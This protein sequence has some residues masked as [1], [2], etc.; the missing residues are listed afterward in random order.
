MEMKTMYNL[1]TVFNFEVK[2]TLKKKS[3]WI[4]S[5]IFPVIIAA[6]FGIIY[7]SNKATSDAANNAQNQHFSIA[8]TDESGLI[9][10]NIL[11]AVK[12]KKIANKQTGITAVKTGKVDAYFYY[13]SDISKD[14]VQIYGKDIG[15]FDNG[16]Y[17]AVAELILK[18]SVTPRVN[19]QI[20]T[21]L[22]AKVNFSSTTYKDGLAYNGFKQLIA[23]GVF[24]VLFYILI[25]MF[26]NQ[27]LTS[28]TEEKENRVIEM[29]LTTIQARTL[30]LGKIYSLVVLALI[31]IIIILIPIITLYLLVGQHLAL[32]NIDL[33]NLPFD[34]VRIGLAAVI[35]FFSFFMFTGL[36]VAIGSAVPTAKEASGFFGAVM[37]LVFGP[38]Y[39]ASLFISAPQSALVQFLSYFPFTAPIPLLLR[40]A[41]GNL[42]VPQALASIA[43]LAVTSVVVMTIAIR[44]FR[45]G[46]L[47]YSK[48]LSFSTIF[49]FKKKQV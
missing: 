49:S 36:L 29:I 6:I 37:A 12:A 18:E 20:S 16:R 26:G 7:F 23:P 2:R 27:M 33:T 24:L 41:V 42:T 10:Q 17:Q 5:I 19:S 43:I 15:L 48:R 1:G 14:N 34:P 31:Q 4:M 9:S 13:P 38:L 22:Q 35:F 21:I 25:A 3:F 46:A 28:T 30:I 32:P 44:L 47:E 8:V 39:A 40:N 45:Y 11:T